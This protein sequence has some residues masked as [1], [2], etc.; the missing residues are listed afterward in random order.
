LMLTTVLSAVA[1]GL[2]PPSAVASPGNDN[3]LDPIALNSP[4]TPLNATNTLQNVTETIGATLQSNIFDPCNRSTCPNGPAE[5]T[6]CQGVAYGKTVWYVFY[7]DHNGQ[8]EIRAKGIPNVITLYTMDPGTRLPHSMQ[9][10]SGSKYAS[11]VL[12]AK[13][14]RGLAYAF[15]IGGR[16]GVP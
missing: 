14:Q 4:G 1:F 10:S 3:Y 5:L 16:N 15:Q 7:P 6:T 12:H 11:N 8:V 9:C 13:V 2:A